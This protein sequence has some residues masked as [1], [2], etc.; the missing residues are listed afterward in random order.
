[1]QGRGRWIALSR[2]R[3]ARL[4]DDLVELGQQAAG[5]FQLCRGQRRKLF[6]VQPGEGLVEHLAQAVDVRQGRPRSFWSDVSPGA[7]IGDVLWRPRNVSYQSNVR[8]LGDS[9]HENDVGRLDVPMDELRL[10]QMFQ[11]V[12]QAQTQ[13]QAF[14]GS[15]PLAPPQLVGQIL[16]RIAPDVD[17]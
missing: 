7:E 14:V 11:G 5:V 12:G 16:R 9:L 2:I 1:M 17:L 8:Q 6:S 13:I 10:V 3:L 15:E 4:E